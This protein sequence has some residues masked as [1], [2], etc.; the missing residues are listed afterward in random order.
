MFEGDSM[1]P[2]ELAEKPEEVLSKCVL[3]VEA[4]LPLGVASNA[5]A[6]LG[7]SL[8][9]HLPNIVGPGVTD[10][11]GASH[12][13]LLTIPLPILQASRETVRTIRQK[14]LGFEDVSVFD[15]TE[16]A[17]KTRT[18]EDYAQELGN[19]QAEQL[20]YIAVALH[21]PASA[22]RKLTGHLKLFS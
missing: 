11:D 17:R 15:F 1:P 22:V 8:G 5:I 7:V 12:Q 10:G 3:V 6:I 9:S 20:R 19:T 4:D 13:G 16:S 18:Y 21:G 14:A 2:T